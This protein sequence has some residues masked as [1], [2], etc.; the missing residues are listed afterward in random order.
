[1]PKNIIRNHFETENQTM[2][3]KLT[4]QDTLL[5]SSFHRNNACIDCEHRIQILLRVSKVAGIESCV[6][7]ASARE[8]LIKQL[9]HAE[10]HFSSTSNSFS[11]PSST[12]CNKSLHCEVTHGP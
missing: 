10:L 7:E 12:I 2:P 5:N 9:Q 3:A 1:M 6:S 11:H 4:F 8:K